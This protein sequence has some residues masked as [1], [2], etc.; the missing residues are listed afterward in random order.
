MSNL[1]RDDSGWKKTFYAVWLAQVCSIT[2]FSAVLPF[3]PLF[4]REL[5]VTEPAA[6]ARWAGIVSSAAAVTMGFF[7]P[8]WGAL[9]D[10][11]GRKPMVVRAMFGGMF[12]LGLMSLSRNVIDLT[13]C[14]LL[15]GCLTGTMTANVALVASVAPRERAGYALGMM[16]AAVFLGHS[17]GPL[18]GG[19]VADHLGYR[20]AFLAAA[21]ML[22]AGG[23]LV[24]FFAHEDFRPGPLTEK[25]GRGD[26]AEVFAAAGFLAAIMALFTIRFANSI[27]NPIFPL[28]VEQVRGSSEGLGTITGFILAVGG[29]AAAVFSGVLGRVSDA[30]GHR[31]VLIWCSVF[32]GVVGGLH[33]FAR[34]VLHLVM[35]RFFF[36]LGAAGVMPSANA[37]IRGGTHDRNLGKAYGV[38]TAATSVGWMA[39]PLAGAMVAAS[40]GLRAPFVLM[41]AALV[42]AAMLVSL[43][44]KAPAQAT[45]A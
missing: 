27:S 7:G 20:P 45:G 31:R 22:F 24:S 9:A 41:G 42:L 8:I 26:F 35:L 1:A 12:V 33:V 39:G 29:L 23:L 37:I 21:A 19:F 6:V 5:G 30:W 36:G 11:Y 10:L 17:I 28:F 43:C 34:N 13:L 14:R 32:A 25:G 38:T 15:Q 18:F 16:Q 3:L 40:M 44:V 4:I 2:G